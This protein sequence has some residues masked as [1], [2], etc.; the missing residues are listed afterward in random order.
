MTLRIK[1]G[2]K[3]DQPIDMLAWCPLCR[4]VKVVLYKGT[5][6]WQKSIVTFTHLPTECCWACQKEGKTLRASEPVAKVETITKE[7][8]TRTDTEW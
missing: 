2:K 1:R 6:A 3:E 8:I 4:S 7:T 5:I